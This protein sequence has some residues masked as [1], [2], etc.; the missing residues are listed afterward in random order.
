MVNGIDPEI[1][2]QI[3]PYVGELKAVVGRVQWTREFRYIGDCLR[4]RGESG[5]PL[6]IRRP[7]KEE[8]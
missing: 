3:E 7:D 5:P 1:M 2:A 8:E 6:W 4:E